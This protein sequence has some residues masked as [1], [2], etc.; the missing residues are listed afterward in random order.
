VTVLFYLYWLTG[1][2]KSRPTGKK[3]RQDG[4]LWY[5]IMLSPVANG[6]CVGRREGIV[7]LFWI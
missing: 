1:N 4:G 2:C 3:Q 5:I 6:W 7:I